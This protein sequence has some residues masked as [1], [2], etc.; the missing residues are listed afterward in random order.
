MYR[1]RILVVEDDEEIADLIQQTLVENNYEAKVCLDSRFI[2]NQVLEYSPDLITLDLNMPKAGGFDV[3]SALSEMIV[4]EIPVLVVS[5]M[6]DEV[7][8]EALKMGASATLGKPFTL[9]EL[10]GRVTELGSF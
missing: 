2:L 8:T 4:R 3:L 6:E 7:L 1:G 9:H 5:G 10:V